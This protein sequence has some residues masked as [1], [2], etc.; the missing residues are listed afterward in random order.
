[1]S[2]TINEKNMGIWDSCNF[3]MLCRKCNMKVGEPQGEKNF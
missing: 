3:G 2:H 1:M